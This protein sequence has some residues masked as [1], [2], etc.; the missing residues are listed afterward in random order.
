MSTQRPLRE[1]MVQM[2]ASVMIPIT[3]AS[4]GW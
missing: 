3:V 4:M 1:M 2:I